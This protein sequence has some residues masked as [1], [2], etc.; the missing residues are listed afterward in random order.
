MYKFTPVLTGQQN[1]VEKITERAWEFLRPIIFG[2]TPWFARRWRN[3][4]VKIVAAVG[5]GNSK[6]IAASAS[7][8]RKSRIDYPW[9]LEIGEHSSIAE[10]AWIYCIDQI[11]IGQNCC[12]GEGVRLL[13]GSHDISSPTFDLVKK[14][15]VISDNVWI[16]TGAIVLPGVHIEEGAV[17]AAGSV[18][19]K[20][21]APWTVVGGNP[22]KLIKNR[23]IINK[24]G[25][26]IFYSKYH[27]PRCINKAA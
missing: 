1:R 21:V 12:I 18:V 26:G 25:G 23:V 4:V 15:I 17:I 10:D 5:G 6:R 14:P 7:L 9:R 22:A 8:G 2:L 16:A 20:D 11:S 27:S 3:V 24:S 13:T 19:A